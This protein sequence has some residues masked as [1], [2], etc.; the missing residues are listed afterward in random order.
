MSSQVFPIRP[1]AE[2]IFP[3]PNNT[4]P[5]GWFYM[6]LVQIPFPF[7]WFYMDSVQIPFPRGQLLLQLPLPPV[8]LEQPFLELKFPGPLCFLLARILWLV[9]AQLC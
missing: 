8:S 7:G 3:F 2:K 9:R 5:F 6:D 1:H 4:F